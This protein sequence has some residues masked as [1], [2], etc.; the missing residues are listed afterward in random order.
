[1]SKWLTVHS[2]TSLPLTYISV[3][4]STDV[5][6]LSTGLVPGSCIVT[7][8]TFFKNL[9]KLVRLDLKFY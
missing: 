7:K 9:E 3:P 6:C 5:Q 2:A 4:K 1:M 8:Q